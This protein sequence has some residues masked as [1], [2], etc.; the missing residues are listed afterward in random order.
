MDVL[1]NIFQLV[2]L[3]LL[4]AWLLLSEFIDTRER[5]AKIQKK[6]PLLWRLM[7]NRPVRFALLISCLGLLAKNYRGTLAL[8]PAPVLTFP[9]PPAP[10]V[11]IT[12]VSPPP[13]AKPVTEIKGND[14]VAGNTVTGTENVVGIG[15]QVTL[16]PKKPNAVQVTYGFNGFE[17][18]IGPGL[19]SGGNGEMTV[20]NQLSSIE[21][22]QDW[23]KLIEECDKEIAKVPLW[24]TPYA[25]KGEA[26]FNLGK[27][28]EGIKLLGYAD[29]QT[30]G[31]PDFDG[32]RKVLAEMKSRL[33]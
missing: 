4:L 12:R 13:Q 25:I 22:S 3:A 15:N 16:N 28:E 9:A 29:S 10:I 7:N 32:I 6:W 11:T 1:R 21:K 19:I 2:P 23:Q 26:L 27:K 30:E 5:L 33:P 20:F 24:I 18:D 8:G 31:N 17:R 14:N